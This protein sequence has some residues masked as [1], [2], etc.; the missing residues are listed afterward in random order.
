MKFSVRDLFWLM[1]VVALA[2]LL[3]HQDQAWQRD[4]DKEQNEKWKLY[5]EILIE[6]KET[7]YWF[8]EYHRE[9]RK[10]QRDV[11][12]ERRDMESY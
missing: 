2:F 9:K 1:L 4:R 10:Y 12:D 5:N 8:D 7:D 3:R 6:K 11:D